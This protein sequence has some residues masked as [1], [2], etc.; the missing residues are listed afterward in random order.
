MN[1]IKNYF[2]IKEK[3]KVHIISDRIPINW[4]E[5]V[6]LPTSSF[7]ILFFIIGWIGALVVG[8]LSAVFYT[9]FRFAAWFYYS[10]I[11]IDIEKGKISLLK[12]ILDN[13]RSE[14]L[15]S[16]S[17]NPDN[18]SFVELNRSGKTKY[19]LRYSSHKDN[20]LLILKNLE[21]KILVEEY[22]SN[23]IPKELKFE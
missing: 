8:I 14:E 13:A 6:I 2:S 15:I 1:D 10:E 5:I 23:E 20:D 12:K 9:P 7:V 4:K 19:L 17:I 18:F 11:Q 21:D 16:N 22:I 3:G